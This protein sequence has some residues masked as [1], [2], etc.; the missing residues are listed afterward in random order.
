MSDFD[1]ISKALGLE[2]Q[3]PGKYGIQAIAK[4][5]RRHPPGARGHAVSMKWTHGLKDSGRDAEEA[6]TRT[7]HVA[8]LK[9]V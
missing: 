1:A 7:K 5:R 9:T 2:P 8:L 4:T 3:L 6:L